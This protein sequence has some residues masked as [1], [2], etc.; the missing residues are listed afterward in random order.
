MRTVVYSQWDGSQAAFSL[1]PEEALRAVSELMMHGLSLPEA[2]EWLRQYGL[3]AGSLSFRIMGIEELVNELRTE[4]ER[5][6]SEYHLDDSTREIEERFDDILDREQAAMVAEHGHESAALNSF[7]E[8]RHAGGGLVE[9]VER[10]RNHPFSD[11]EAG[12]DFEALLSELDEIGALERFIAENAGRFHGQKPADYETAQDIRRRVEELER[13]VAALSRGE[14]EGIKPEDLA[15]LLGDDAARSLV[16]LRDLERSLRERGYTRDGADGPELTAR[17]VR[18]IGA[19][20]LADVYSSI[21]KD[22]AGEHATSARGADLPRPDETR[23]YM[24]G[25]GLSV[26]V[27]RSVMNAVRRASLSGGRPALPIRLRYDDLEVRELDHATDTTTVLLL[28]LSWSMSFEGRFP[29]AKRVA[30]ALEHLIRSAYPRDRFFAVG[31]STRARELPPE[32]LAGVSWDSSDPFTNLQAG[33]RLASEII[34]KNP[35]ANAQVI[36]I[37]DGQPTAYYEGSELRAE[38]PMGPGAVSPRAVAETM[39]EVRAITRRG[40][41]INTFMIDDAP[42]L[43]GFV[44]RMTEVNRGR[45]F[46]TAP[47]HLGSFLLVDYVVS[48]RLRRR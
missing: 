28:D 24:F 21:A 16:F 18:K 47:A 39:R 45:A 41:T 11:R 38:W 7:F 33:L 13:L 17:A 48:R 34:A 12:E 23:P 8:K 36:V 46:F 20:A 27:T 14:L 6:G 31:F 32:D 35:S 30:L 40:V 22:R 37:T 19:Q 26:D 1:D 43:V 29:A 4:L 3:S 9:R 44:E 25:D 15:R 5:L 42:E 2:I 10:F